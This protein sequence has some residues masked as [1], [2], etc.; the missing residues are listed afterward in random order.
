MNG[1]VSNSIFADNTSGNA[2][3]H[4]DG[5]YSTGF[6]LF[7]NDPVSLTTLGDIINANAALGPLQDNGGSVLTMA[8]L[9]S[10][11][12]I[13][14]GTGTSRIDAKGNKSNE[15]VDIGAVEYLSTGDTKKVY[16]TDKDGDVIFRATES[17]GNQ[18]V[19]SRVQQI[20]LP[21]LNP[22]PDEFRP[23]DIVVNESQGR[24]YW[25]EKNNSYGR[26]VS[27]NLDGTNQITVIDNSIDNGLL[28]PGGIAIDAENDHI[29]LTSDHRSIH[30][31]DHPLQENSIR[32]YAID[33]NSL[34]FD[35]VVHSARSNAE[36]PIA[37]PQGI[38]YLYNPVT[39]EKWLIWADTGVSSAP[40]PVIAALNLS[41]ANG[42]VTYLS[43][44]ADA[45]PIRVA[46]NTTSAGTT[47]IAYYA[48]QHF[49]LGAVEFDPT[50]P[51]LVEYI[52]S[53]YAG[54]S[55]FTTGIHY[56]P[57]RDLVWYTRSPDGVSAGSIWTIE[58]DLQNRFEVQG[59]VNTPTS[60]TL[61]KSSEIDQNFD[62]TN[63]VLN[64]NSGAPTIIL[65]ANLE[66]VDPDTLPLDIHYSVS[67]PP[68]NGRL[69]LASAPGI[70][71]TTFSQHQINN[72][73]IVYAHNGVNSNTDS[74]TFS[75]TDGVY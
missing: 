35:S 67:V 28:E 26:V 68:T 27:A 41:T 74:I 69:E 22:G 42:E 32:R 38:D 8:P 37:R 6:N 61:A 48:D 36:Y 71:I 56:D 59:S 20:T 13:D 43:L 65:P 75:V 50:N 60:I 10:S 25:I 23:V 55:N 46:W 7:D 19:L 34:T 64:I 72:S 40:E 29:Y 4:L 73:Q 45:T 9:A 24:I 1:V 2:F 3:R 11:D 51:S 49:N 57:D 30:N 47:A 62:L 58:S 12:A 53:Q 52:P 5:D 66:A 18:P 39:G 54:T 15:Y 33:G 17:G 63:N 70:A 31:I 44:P 16:W 21:T 14:S